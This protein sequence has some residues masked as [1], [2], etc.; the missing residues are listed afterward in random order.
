MKKIVGFFRGIQKGL[1]WFLFG[2]IIFVLLIDGL[3]RKSLGD[4]GFLY[5]II[6][7]LYT[8]SLSYI[9]SFVFYCIQVHY[10]EMKD[11]VKVLPSV[12]SLFYRLLLCCNNVVMDTICGIDPSKKIDSISNVTKEDFVNAA[13]EV[14]FDSVSSVF[15]G[16]TQLTWLQ[17]Y[18]FRQKQ[19]DEY[20]KSVL[21]FAHYLDE[22]CISLLAE[23][24]NDVFLFLLVTHARSCEEAGMQCTHL[25][26]GAESLF[27]QYYELIVRMNELYTVKLKPFKDETMTHVRAIFK[28]INKQI[29]L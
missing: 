1:I 23:L 22:E 2:C 29:V 16:D 6:N 8:I 19:I 15:Q 24:R 27:A 20:R 17:Y 18:S 3:A 4:E 14:R 5:S 10:K 21:D 11:E 26:A 28:G 9:A 12:E 13:K 7:I 25:M